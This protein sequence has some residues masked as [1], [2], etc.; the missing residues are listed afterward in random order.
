MDTKLYAPKNWG[1]LTI[2][3]HPGNLRRTDIVWHLMRMI[4]M[5]DNDLSAEEAIDLLD[6]MEEQ[7]F[8]ALRN[9]AEAELQ[10]P[11]MQAY[12]ERK[13]ISPGMHLHPTT[14][15]EVTEVLNEWPMEAF[16]RLELP[17]V[18]WQ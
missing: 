14:L 9:R 16:L 7:E 8:S 6:E 3:D 2:T 18:E 4:L 17:E 13:Q 12:L 11:Q 10:E 1:C 15:E 5:S